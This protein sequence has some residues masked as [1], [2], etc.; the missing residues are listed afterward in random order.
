MPTDPASC[1]LLEA[2]PP[3]WIV[4]LLCVTSLLVVLEAERQRA[5]RG[6]LLPELVLRLEARAPRLL[7]SLCA[8][9]FGLASAILF[10]SLLLNMAAL[11]LSWAMGAGSQP[12]LI[13]LSTWQQQ[14]HEAAQA[15]L[16]ADGGGG[17]DI[18]RLIKQQPP[19]ST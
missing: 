2:R 4:A 10:L 11:G 5:P 19:S 3:A 12:S 13:Q 1:A 17:I 8:L 14:Q 9:A 15:A 6:G 18:W 16:L 7:L